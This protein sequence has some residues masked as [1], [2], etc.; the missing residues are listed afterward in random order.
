MVK[1]SPGLHCH[2]G[3][4]LKSS[5]VADTILA[6]VGLVNSQLGL[7]SF[8]IGAGTRIVA[9]AAIEDGVSESWGLNRSRSARPEAKSGSPATRNCVLSFLT[10][11]LLR[12]Q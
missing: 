1:G 2:W 7:Q 4:D 11:R 9:R 5:S 10:A 8:A 6:N 12:P 3:R